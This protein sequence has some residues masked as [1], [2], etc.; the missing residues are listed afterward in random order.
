MPELPEVETVVR[1]VRPHIVGR[2][3]LEAK[4]TSQHV[5]KG[6]RKAF[7]ERLI[8]RKIESVQRRGKFICVSLDQGS[9]SIHLGMTGNL[10]VAE[11]KHGKHTYGE[12]RFDQ[13][14]LLFNDPRQFGKIEWSAG[15]PK[16]ASALG[17]EPLG[18]SLEDF[19]ARLKRK[20]H[21]KPLLL[22]QKFLAG[23]GNI[24]ADES[25]FASGIHPLTSAA[26]IS[27]PRAARL[28][29]AIQSILQDA[30]D[31]HGST[32]SDYRT[33]L[34]DEGGYQQKHKVYGRE[35]EPCVVCSTPIRKVVV[36]QRGTHFCPACQKR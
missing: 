12:F 16:R 19:R 20:A 13:G 9:L 7:A 26:K 27:A 25:L 21:I 17:P 6:D 5:V 28:H 11:E 4:F 23:V 31:A 30:I 3:I 29:H 22:N 34:G 15:E 35:G 14:I 8:G 18:I 24:Y 10:F 32:I 33:A 2:T 1:T 36:G